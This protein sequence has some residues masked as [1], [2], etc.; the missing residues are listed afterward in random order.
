ML[1]KC[2]KC[3]GRGF[4]VTIQTG[5]HAELTDG[6]VLRCVNKISERFISAACCHCDKRFTKAAFKKIEFLN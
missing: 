3:G 6:G 4:A 2:G 1:N 5:Y